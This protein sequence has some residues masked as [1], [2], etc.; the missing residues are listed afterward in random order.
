MTLNR[1]IE[2][3][4]NGRKERFH[5]G[6]RPFV[7]LSYAQSWDGSI[8]TKQGRSMALSGAEA[9]GLTHQL[10]SLHDGILVGIETV[11]SDDPQLTVREWSGANPQ[12]I[13]L[14]TTVRMPQSA[15]LCRHPDKQCW[16][17]TTRTRTDRDCPG[18]EIIV[19]PDNGGKSVPL[20]TALQLLRERGIQSLMVE[21][22]ARVI[23]AFLRARLV[24]VLVLTVVPRLLGGYK[25]V[26][27]FDVI[28][29]EERPCIDPLFSERLG[30]DLIVWGDI[31][32]G[33]R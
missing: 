25:A 7:T 31:R 33:S 20:D 23:S 29:V 2:D 12:P 26:S 27:N 19:V 30:D 4:L 15:H 17:L 5:S 18:A 16:V 22:G 14:D 1:Q 32:Y 24:D 11:L 9:K 28:P 10:R 21:G 13:V 3:W 8:T 6:R